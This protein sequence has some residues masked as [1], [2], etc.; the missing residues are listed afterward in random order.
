[1]KD[2]GWVW[3]RYAYTSEQ[4]LGIPGLSVD[5][6]LRAGSGTVLGKHRRILPAAFLATLFFAFPKSFSYLRVHPA[7][8]VLIFRSDSSFF[9]SRSV[10]VILGARCFSSLHLFGSIPS[11]VAQSLVSEYHL[12]GSSFDNYVPVS[13]YFSLY[14]LWS[15]FRRP[16]S[17]I[18]SIL[19]DVRAVQAFTNAGTQQLISLIPNTIN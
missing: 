17:V 2:D 5:L 10:I 19:G 11:G 3:G 16:A 15:S 14:S 6:A 7:P 4:H 12:L 18:L 1:M 8:P 9:L 13:G